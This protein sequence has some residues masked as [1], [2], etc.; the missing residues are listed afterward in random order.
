MTARLLSELVEDHANMRK[1]LDILEKQ[2]DIFTAGGHPDWDLLADI[3]EYC[4][5]Y[6]D[7]YHHPKED[8]V[9]RKVHERNAERA[10]GAGRLIA[11]H[12]KLAAEAQAF[13]KSL[14]AIRSEAEVPR[15]RL[16][17]LLFDFVETYRAHMAMEEEFFFPAAD[18]TL[19]AADWH[20]IRAEAARFDPLFGDQ[21]HDRFR[22]LRAEILEWDRLNAATR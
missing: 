20:T 4:L 10:K 3:A 7:R 11:Q 9:Y 17:A 16:T 8:L 22:N 15:D 6:P 19:T 1:L 2:R 12:A 5:D 13:A 18:M 21:A 14:A